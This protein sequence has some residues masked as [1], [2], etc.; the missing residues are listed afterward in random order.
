MAPMVVKTTDLVLGNE[1]CFKGG[2]RIDS[3]IDANGDSELSADEIESTS[4][5][6]TTASVNQDYNFKRVAT[7]PVCS[8]IDPDCNTDTETAAE[9][10]AAS[11]DGNTLIYSDSPL[12]ALGFVDISNSKSPVALGTLELDGEP[13]SVAVKGDYVLVGVNTSPDLDNPS[14]ELEVVDIATRTAIRTLDLGGQPD[15]VAVSPDGNYAA[16]II[17]NERDEDEVVDG[18]EGGL[19]QAPAGFLVIVDL[20]DNDPANWATSNVDLTGLTDVAVG[21]TD[22]EPEYVDINNNNI[23]VVTLQEN[24]HLALVNLTNGEVVNNFTAGTVDLTQV[25]IAEEDIISQTESLTNVPREPDGVAWINSE[26]FAT[27]DEG[28]FEGGSRGF[29][30]FNT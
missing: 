24:N 22:P 12:E 21:E 2:I 17:E 28:D 18:V 29:T 10:V 16:V 19:P 23:A 4:Y 20:S 25:D 9:I 13:T 26:Y 7:F 3:G 8:Q 5:V 1:Q 15:S 27:A 30:I 6:C 14:G 11:S